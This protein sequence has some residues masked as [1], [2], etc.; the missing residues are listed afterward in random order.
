MLLIS[1]IARINVGFLVMSTRCRIASRTV[2]A[3]S[4]AASLRVLYTGHF[5]WLHQTSRASLP[6]IPLT[7]L[8]C[9]ELP[10]KLPLGD[11][12]LTTVKVGYNDYTCPQVFRPYIQ[13]SLLQVTT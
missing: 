1:S 2:S 12:K 13:L 11:T 7:H 3:V 9:P 8:V 4:T 5:K 10:V 6:A